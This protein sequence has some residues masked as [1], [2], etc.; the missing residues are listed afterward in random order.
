MKITRYGGRK[1]MSEILLNDILKLEKLDNVKIR[2]ISNLHKPHKY[3]PIRNF[4]A[5]PALL[6]HELYYNH[7]EQYFSEGEIT[8]GLVTLDKFFTETDEWMLFHIGKVTKDLKISHDVGYEWEILEEYQKYFGRLVIK[9]HNE[10]QNLVRKANGLIQEL[11]VHKVLDKIN[12]NIGEKM[13]KE[14]EELIEELSNQLTELTKQEKRHFLNLAGEFSVCAELLKRNVQANVTFGNQKSTDVT[15]IDKDKKVKT[16]EVKTSNGKRF[17]I[18]FYQKF[19]PPKSHPA[20]DFWV[21]VHINSETF[22]SDFYVLTH[23]QLADETKKLFYQNKEWEVQKGLDW[24]ELEQ[25]EKYKNDWNKI[26]NQ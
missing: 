18:S 15:V 17:L 6:Q 22:H 13:T 2:F 23:E 7:N 4:N 1:L 19:P 11:K 10:S 5:N 16:V 14:N 26:L 12:I 20:P 21:F 8:V 24:I 9:Y 3:C 25:L